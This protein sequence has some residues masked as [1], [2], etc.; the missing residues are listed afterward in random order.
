MVEMSEPLLDKDQTGRRMYDLIKRFA[1][2][3]DSIY[4]RKSGKLVPLSKLTVRQFFDLIRR[5]KYRRDTKPIEVVARPRHIF[6]YQ[7]LG[8]DCKKKSVAMGSWCS[9]NSVPWRLIASSSR[10]D[11]RIHHVFCQGRFNGR[12]KNLDATYAKYRPFQNKNVT[13]AE[14]LT[15]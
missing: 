7:G 5:M 12:W 10:P 4:V 6:R 15:R 9:L 14:V 1:R 2:D 8:M 11:R 3:L 13:A